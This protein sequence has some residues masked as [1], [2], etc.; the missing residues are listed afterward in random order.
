MLSDLV[1]RHG[2]CG[3]RRRRHTRQPPRAWRGKPRDAVVC[4]QRTGDILYVPGGWGH[5][6]VNEGSGS[7]PLWVVDAHGAPP[8]RAFGAPSLV[9]NRLGAYFQTVERPSSINR[10]SVSSE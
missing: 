10:G 4:E 6:V 1:G 3:R 8:G 5:A 9:G 2:T 7:A